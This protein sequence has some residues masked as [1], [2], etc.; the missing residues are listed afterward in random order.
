ME[1][2]ADYFLGALIALRIRQEV[3][4]LVEFVMAVR[5]FWNRRWG[6]RP[7]LLDD[8]ERSRVALNLAKLN[9]VVALWFLAISRSP[10]GEITRTRSSL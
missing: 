6:W 9:L 5:G 4:C 2:G 1:V 8:S 10:S 7:Q 3:R